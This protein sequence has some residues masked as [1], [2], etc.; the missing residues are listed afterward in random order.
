M[1]NVVARP[2]RSYPA[3]R[4]KRIDTCVLHARTRMRLEQRANESVRN[5][6]FSFLWNVKKKK[7]NKINKNKNQKQI[8][9]T[10]TFVL[11][12]PPRVLETTNLLFFIFRDVTRLRTNILGY[13]DQSKFNEYNS[14]ISFADGEYLSR[15]DRICKQRMYISYIEWVSRV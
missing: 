9:K 1:E 11:D 3:Y 2:R 7:K 4:C 5:R 14:F 13:Y 15:D 8:V 6:I 10:R 12:N